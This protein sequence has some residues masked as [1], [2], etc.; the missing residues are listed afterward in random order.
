MVVRYQR[1]LL[2]AFGLA[3]T[4]G[5]GSS[6]PVAGGQE[7]VPAEVAREI[8]EA[9][10][11][12]GGFVVHLNC[13]HG[14]LTA[15]LRINER[16]QVHGLDDESSNV[17]RARATIQ[18]AGLYGDV[19]VDQLRGTRL[20]YIDNLV[21]LLVSDDLGNVSMSEVMRVLTPG[22]V[23]YLRQAGRWQKTVKRRPDNIDD[24]SHFL[25][26]ASGNAVAHDEVVGP[27]RHLQWLGS[28]RWSRHHDRMASMS[29]LVSAGGR[30]FYI[31]DEGA[32]CF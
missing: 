25:H 1:I 13:A 20:P 28:P 18:R 7:P 32:G 26:D 31:M 5:S 2:L 11:I 24:W 15:A 12:R 3:L 21:N 30:I 19:S 22:G 14:E 9:T 29:A 16:F 23:A 4:A 17:A 8:V 27:P 10:G 6:I